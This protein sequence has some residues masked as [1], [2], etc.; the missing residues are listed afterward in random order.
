MTNN[1]EKAQ[2]FV[3]RNARP[4]NL[5]L[6]QYHF[7]KGSSDNVIKALSYYQN[8]DGGF[9]NALEADCFNPFSS[10]IQ[11]WQATEILR[12]IG[13]DDKNHPIV[14]G[15]LRYLNSGDSFSSEHNQWEN[16]I[17][18]NNDF[19]HAIWWEYN[20]K[21]QYS[22]NPSACLAGFILKFA[23]PNSELFSKA[24]VIAKQAFDYFIN[25]VPFSEQHVTTCFIRLFEYC[26][27]SN[28]D[29]FDMNLLKQKLVE[30]VNFNLCRDIEKWGIDYVTIPSYFVSSKN[31]IFYDGNE[32]LVAAE[33]DFIKKN[34]LPDGSYNVAWQWWTDYKEFELSANWWKSQICLEKMRFLKEFDESIK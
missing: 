19:P 34:Q 1:F 15:I 20:E 8:D 10:P 2:R 24:T 14:A 5:A 17:P 31:S 21:R 22:Y 7:E 25:A 6:W 13:F 30:Q 12:E 9:G 11:T 32:E 33:V 16:V 3:Y 27:E 26:S 4:I 18:T 29:I 23:D 28:I